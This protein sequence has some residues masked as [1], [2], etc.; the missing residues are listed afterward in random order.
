MS[1]GFGLMVFVAG[2]G[3]DARVDIAAAGAMDSLA[4]AMET[5]VVEYHAETKRADDSLEAAVVD[6]FVARIKRDVSDDAAVESHSAAFR[7]ALGRVRDD[8]E[9]EM[10]RY[11]A[12]LDNVGVLR[13]V[14]R[15]LRRL[16]M[17][18]LSLRDDARR[19]LFSLL[20]AGRA[21]LSLE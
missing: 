14:S 6:S 9:V 3:G 12:A 11:R 8:R 5:V 20:E 15:G 21:K 4:K 16:G 13:E 17:E 7:S 10:S 18:S 2:C 19:Y 1:V